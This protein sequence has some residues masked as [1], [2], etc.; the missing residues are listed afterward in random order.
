MSDWLSLYYLVLFLLV[1]IFF[2]NIW[3]SLQIKPVFSPFVYF[4]HLVL[5]Q[6]NMQKKK[7]R[8]EKTEAIIVRLEHEEK[9]KQRDKY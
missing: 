8:E 7:V 6:P 5:V 1:Y 3:A 4:Q 9:K 2:I